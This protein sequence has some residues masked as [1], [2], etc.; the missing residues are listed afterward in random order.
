[1]LNLL[2]HYFFYTQ[3]IG[4]TRFTW[5]DWLLIL[6]VV[7]LVSFV[8]VVIMFLQYEIFNGLLSIKFGSLTKYDSILNSWDFLIIFEFFKGLNR[9]L[10][11]LVSHNL[12]VTLIVIFQFKIFIFLIIPLIFLCWFFSNF[13]FI[14]VV[15]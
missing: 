14:L 2:L 12:T 13:K 3:H 7:G 15:M 6:L 5:S 10:R 1:M 4:L 9:A 11:C 8:I